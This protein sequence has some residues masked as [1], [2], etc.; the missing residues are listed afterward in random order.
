MSAYAALSAEDL[1]DRYRQQQDE[2]ALHYL[3]S[4]HPFTGRLNAMLYKLGIIHEHDREDMLQELHIHLHRCGHQ[5]D[6]TRAGLLTWLGWKARR[7]RADY[8]ADR[9]TRPPA[10]AAAPP[11][12]S[13]ELLC[14]DDATFDQA[15]LPAGQ[16]TQQMIKAVCNTIYD[17]LR[18]M[19]PNVC[20]L[21]FD[22]LCAGKEYT[23]ISDSTGRKPAT[24][25]SDFMRAVDDLR[26]ALLR[27]GFDPAA[28]DLLADDPEAFRVR[29]SDLERL[30]DDSLRAVCREYLFEGASTAR[31]A[32]TFNL[33]PREVRDRLARGMSELMHL[34]RRS[35]PNTAPEPA[36][37]AEVFDAVADRLLILGLTPATRTAGTTHSLTATLK[38]LFRVLSC[39]GESIKLTLG[40]CLRERQAMLGLSL[41]ALAARLQ[42]TPPQLALLL[43]DSFPADNFTPAL[44]E[45]LREVFSFT[46]D[47]L[48]AFIDITARLAPAAVAVIAPA[49][50]SPS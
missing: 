38:L 36:L 16:E 40:A 8:F 20:A 15:A 6:R 41:D 24:L 5:Y 7:M 30:A 11:A 39:G 14:D 48:A 37:S 10:D 18:D 2:R 32:R 45:R 49:P 26:A 50:V 31:M 19:E 28:L 17:A 12:D 33:T 22:R 43:T 13:P 34:I 25:R 35:A 1:F 44:Q 21:F 27:R 42:L 46:R 9:G 3:L 29:H 23:E 47:E 4:E